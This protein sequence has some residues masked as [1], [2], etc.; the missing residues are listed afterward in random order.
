MNLSTTNYLKIKM[1]CR[2]L[3]AAFVPLGG[4]ALLALSACAINNAP[5]PPAT[6]PPLAPLAGLPVQPPVVP[7]LNQQILG[8]WMAGYPGG[9]FRVDIQNDPLLGGNNYIATLADGGYGTFH[10]GE[11]VFKATPDQVVPNLVTGTQRCPDPPYLSPVDL[12]MTITVADA[13]N[14]TEDLVHK[15][16]C[17]GFP[18]KFT[19]GSTPASP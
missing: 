14:F 6:P 8:P 3:H 17:K 9:P 5:P 1:L 15:G 4:A 12:S 7:N 10:A 19:R 16:A 2:S 18:V 13:N 11:I